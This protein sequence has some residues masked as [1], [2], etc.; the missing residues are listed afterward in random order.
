MATL[1]GE[2]LPSSFV[3]SEEFEGDVRTTVSYKVEGEGDERQ[4]FKV[5]RKAR[6]REMSATESRKKM[7]KFGHAKNAGA[8]VDPNTTSES[9]DDILIEDPP[10]VLDEIDSDAEDEKKDS[11]FDKI[12]SGGIQVSSKWRSRRQ[13]ASRRQEEEEQTTLHI[14]DL[15]KGIPE[16]EMNADVRELFGKFGR[17]RRV[18][19]GAC[20]HQLLADLL[21]PLITMF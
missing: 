16:E 21:C 3:V 2:P 18:F 19:I 15:P 13:E 17:I 4:I 7:D 5:T 6:V 12:A 1:E 10:S 8:G 20:C 14:N 9:K 11:V